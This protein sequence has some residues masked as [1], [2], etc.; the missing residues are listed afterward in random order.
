MSRK[1]AS[2]GKHKCLRTLEK[3]EIS[4]NHMAYWKVIALINGEIEAV[5]GLAANDRPS[6]HEWTVWEGQAA[7]KADVLQRAEEAAPRVDRSAC[8]F[9]R[10][11]RRAIWLI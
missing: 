1:S 9:A 5:S 2:T 8:A 10:R 4:D 7:N 11:T 6:A 3:Q